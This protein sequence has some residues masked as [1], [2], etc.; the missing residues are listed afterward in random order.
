M[1][2]T[3][4]WRQAVAWRDADPDPV[5]RAAITQMIDSQDVGALEAH[6]GSGLD[7]GTGGMRGPMGPGP[8]R[9]N[10]VVI[11][12]VTAALADHLVAHVPDARSMGVAVSYDARVN[13]EVF[14]QDAARVLAGRGFIVHLA[15]RATPTPL[16]SFATPALGAAAGVII[17][18]SHNPA[19]DNGYKVFWTTGAQIIAPTDEGVRRAMEALSPEVPAPELDLVADQV[20]TWPMAVFDA[21]DQR[22]AA[23]RVHRTTGARIVYT[24]MHGVGLVDVVRVLGQ[25]GHQDLHVVASQ[26][27]P[28]GRFPTVDFPN[29]EEAGALD[30][31]IQLADAVQAD[32]ILANDPDADR[33]AVAVP[34]GRGG[35]TQLSGNQLGVLIAEDLLAHGGAAPTD[36]VVT[37]IV[38]TAMLAQI[39]RAHHVQVAE[40]LTG[41]KWI[42]DRALRH[43]AEGGRFRFGFEESIGYSLGNVVR[44]KDGVSAALYLADLAS[45]AK[46]QGR[47]LL[48]L[49]DDLYRVHGLHRGRQRSLRLPGSDGAARIQAAMAALR[50]RAPTSL[51]GMVVQTATDIADGVAVSSDGARRRVDLPPS[52]VLAYELKGGHRVLV[53]PS[54][55][56]P[57]IK[58]YLE[59]V[60]PLGAGTSVED[61]TARAEGLLDRL[62]ADVLARAGLA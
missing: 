11:R 50:A 49:L 4:L 61:A 62:E 47:T 19:A 2:T 13:S 5:T 38:S 46:A 17:T 58:I 28:D 15:P 16:L 29:P 23:L 8:A 14:A 55:T 57:K 44:D 32:I 40:T 12:R 22:V 37:T 26:A 6:F 7:F 9:M 48:D 35:W 51:A 34:D 18:A 36:L 54:G 52:D 39:A 56:E 59:V 30:E 21:Y 43:E 3:T 42:A 41:F 25:A 24:P 1:D 45:W 53:R 27:A 33:L 20:R 31:A 10:R 60:E